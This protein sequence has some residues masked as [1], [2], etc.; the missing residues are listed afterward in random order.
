MRGVTLP[1]GELFGRPCTR[2]CRA[3]CPGRHPCASDPS[4][5]ASEIN[6]LHASSRVT[7]SSRFEVGAMN[8]AGIV[9]RGE[10]AGD[11]ESDCG[12]ARAGSSAPS[13]N[14][15]RIVSPCTYSET[16]TRW[17]RSRPAG[18]IVATPWCLSCPPPSLPG[19]AARAGGG[20]AAP[21]AGSVLMATS[22]P[23]CRWPDTRRPC[24]R[25]RARD[26]C[27]RSRVLVPSGACRGR[28]DRAWAGCSR[29]SPAVS[30]VA[31]SAYAV[32]Q[33]LVVVSAGLL[34]P[35]AAGIGRLIEG[36]PERPL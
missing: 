27:D 30:C 14:N 2:V 26:R 34:Q 5:C 1:T 20:P 29:K 10:C 13:R 18:R 25:V 22:D 32:A 24:R 31:R 12:V 36:R 3:S 6:Q 21:R 16:M 17:R 4:M 19:A 11:F 8:D 23:G 15:V 35:R 33:K 28:P 9:R 7:I